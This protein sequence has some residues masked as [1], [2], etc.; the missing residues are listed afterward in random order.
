[1]TLASKIIFIM[2]NLIKILLIFI[3]F[4][5]I[6]FSQNFEINW[7]QCYGGSDRDYARDI[8]EITDGYLIAGSTKSNDGDISYNHGATDCWLIKT[9]NL[10]NLIWEKTFEGAMETGFSGLFR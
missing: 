6:A 3:S 1:M 5:N 2:K 7:Q 4:S 8:T 10:G 9:D